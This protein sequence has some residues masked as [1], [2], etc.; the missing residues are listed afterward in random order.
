MIS[1]TINEHDMEWAY[2]L[3]KAAYDK[4]K[5]DAEKKKLV[6]TRKDDPLSY[7]VGKLGEVASW[8]FLEDNGFL[9]EPCFAKDDKYPDIITAMP[10]YVIEVKSWQLYQWNAEPPLG[11]SIP[12]NQFSYML[13]RCQ[14]IFWCTVDFQMRTVYGIRDLSDVTGMFKRYPFTVEIMSYSW[15]M[16]LWKP[17]V[18]E[19]VAITN[20]ANVTLYSKQMTAMAISK[21]AIPAEK[22][23]DE[24]R[25]KNLHNP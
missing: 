10:H 18:W 1:I 15:A 3:A 22:F 11:H 13:P 19:D 7:V 16:N 21:Y 17:G 9:P 12:I 4:Y 25:E 2:E 5:K 8:R 24:I 14:L 6:K 20:K 23:V